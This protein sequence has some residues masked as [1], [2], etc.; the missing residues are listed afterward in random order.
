MRISDF[1]EDEESEINVAPLLDCIFLLL[2]F[3]L[4]T[5]TIQKTDEDR[6]KEVQQ[7]SLELPEAAASAEAVAG[8]TVLVIQVDSSGRYFMNDERVGL[9]ELHRR[10]RSAADKHPGIRIEGDRRVAFDAVA[11]VV[12]LCE[13]EGLKEISIRTK[14]R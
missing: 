4:L 5:S 13:F 12:D 6:K 2:I 8:K 7:L 11:H 14:E 10:L 1:E 3:F 9:E